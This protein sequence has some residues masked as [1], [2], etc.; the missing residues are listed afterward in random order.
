LSIQDLIQPFHLGSRG[1]PRNFISVA[2]V[3]HGI[4]NI[5]RGI[6]QTL[7]GKL[8]ALLMIK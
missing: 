1:E 7:R 3:I 8:W 2:E 4:Y 6:R 5:C